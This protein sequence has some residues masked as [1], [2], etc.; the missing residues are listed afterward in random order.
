[1]IIFKNKK[2]KFILLGILVLGFLF[3]LTGSLFAVPLPETFSIEPNNFFKPINF[4]SSINLLISLSAISLVPFFLISTT[5]FLRI[6]IVLSM[7]RNAIGTQQSPPNVVIIS[8]ALFMTVFIMSPVWKEVDRIAIKPYQEKKISQSVAIQQGLLPLR[9]FMLKFT[10]EKDLA[11]FLEFAGMKRIKKITEIPT[12]VI[13]PAFIIS[14]LKTAFQIGFL[15]F[16]P[17]VVIDLI[18]SNVLLSLG[19]FMLSPVMV[20]LPFKIL[21]FVVTDGWNLITKG[22][23]LSFQ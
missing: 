1:M 21:L 7:L 16:I 4:S 5:S 6:V 9:T 20:S 3:F 15:L 19:M 14:E 2:I 12:T 13:I 8:L 23:I 18:V 22:L 11:L 10:R 17:F